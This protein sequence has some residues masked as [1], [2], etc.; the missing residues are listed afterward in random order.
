MQQIRL[1]LQEW[2]PVLIR[3][4]HQLLEQ[5]SYK[6]QLSSGLFHFFLSPRYFQRWYVDQNKAVD[7]NIENGKT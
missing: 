7:I 6:S 5:A 3:V 1:T 2:R 4:L